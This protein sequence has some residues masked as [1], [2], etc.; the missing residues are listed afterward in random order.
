MR[1]AAYERARRA[2]KDLICLLLV[3]LARANT[4]AGP[5]PDLDRAE[6]L[7]W[8]DT[9]AAL[10]LLDKLQPASQTGDAQIQW[11]MARGIASIEEDQEQAQAI[12][13]MRR[14]IQRLP[15]ILLRSYERWRSRWVTSSSCLR[16]IILID[17]APRQA[18]LQGGDRACLITFVSADNDGE[19]S[20]INKQFDLATADR[21]VQLVETVGTTA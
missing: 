1:T 4:Q 14:K 17:K 12:C 19:L 6:L 10:R 9:P 3:S 11:L 18:Q 5:I 13:S 7:S 16:A 8:I 2:A 20:A 21:R 15:R